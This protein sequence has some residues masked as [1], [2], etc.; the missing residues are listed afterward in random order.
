MKNKVKD[1]VIIWNEKFPLDLWWRK[2][3]GVAFM[4]KHHKSISF[5]DQLFEWEEEQM[6]NEALEEEMKARGLIE[7]V[8]ERPEE[9]QIKDMQSEFEQFLKEQG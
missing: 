5:L 9:E 2:K 4:S 3:H 7:E 6:Y 1:Q 8:D